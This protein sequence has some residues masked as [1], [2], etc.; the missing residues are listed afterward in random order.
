MAD[1]S[2]SQKPFDAARFARRVLRLME[3]RRLS[4]REAARETGVSP[5]TMSRVTRGYSPNIE[6]YTRLCRWLERFGA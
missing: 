6:T 4:V 1:S 3:G 5:A 2:A